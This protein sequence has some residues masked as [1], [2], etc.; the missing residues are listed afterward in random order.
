[1]I[2]SKK[3]W[4][5]IY[6]E[7]S[8]ELLGICLRYVKD[9]SLAE[10]L[11]HDAFLTAINKL[12]TYKNIGSFNGWLKKIVV[13]TIL[14]YLRHNKKLDNQHEYDDNVFHDNFLTDNLINYKH[15]ISATD[16]SKEEI[17]ESLNYLPIHHRIVF[18]LYVIEGYK[19]LQISKMLKTSVGTS[20]SCLSRARKKLI[21]IL[22]E[23]AEEKINEE[24]KKRKVWHFYGFFQFTKDLSIIYSRNI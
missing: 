1:M 23:R 3:N 22:S 21:K 20:K 11:L 24:K 7:Q 16:F 14:Q 9:K 4:N 6:K 5:L 10:D 19:H 17:L 15:S 18:N 12:D 13:N 2:F 8:P